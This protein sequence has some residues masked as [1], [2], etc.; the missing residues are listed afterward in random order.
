[1]ETKYTLDYWIDDGWYVGK[2]REIPGVFSQGE[3]VNEL[4]ENIRDAYKLVFAENETLEQPVQYESKESV[5]SEAIA[6]F[7][8]HSFSRPKGAEECPESCT[9]LGRKPA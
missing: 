8:E 3:T 5:I 6:T 9:S 1:M 2:L 4:E 7:Q